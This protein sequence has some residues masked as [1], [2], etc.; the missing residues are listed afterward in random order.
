ME[1]QIQVRLL[2][3]GSRMCRLTVFFSLER[4]AELRENLDKVANV[5]EN[6]KKLLLKQ[7]SLG[8]EVPSHWFSSL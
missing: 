5:I 2:E 1:K 4:G 6:V 7:F 8:V 3:Q